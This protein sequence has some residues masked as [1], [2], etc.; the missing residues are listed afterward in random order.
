MFNKINNLEGQV[1]VITG[2][3][4]GIGFA[5][6]AR[7][8]SLGATVIAV[9]RSDL[10]QM[11]N[12]LDELSSGNLAVLADITNSQSLLD[13]LNKINACDILI[14]SAGYSKKIP[15]NDLDELTDE[16]FDKIM[17]TNLRGV[18]A[19]IK[20]FLPLLKKSNNGLIINISSVSA[21]KTGGSNIAYAASKAGL[22][23][24]T[25]NLAKSIAP[26]RVISIAP[27]AIDTG[28]LDYTSEY[29]EKIASATPL[30][31]I[32]TPEDI[33]SAVEAYATTLRFT[34]GNSIIVDGGICL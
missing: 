24:M 13:I 14:N 34:T 5:I 1:A 27:S 33:A 16:I 22:D 25:R 30:K 10:N 21:I 2:A 3:A 29:Y 9:V 28:F 12:R 32:G 17:Q 23:S 26:I 6:A 11:Q 31:R 20:T 19:T 7:L 4:G 8:I 15:H 18:F